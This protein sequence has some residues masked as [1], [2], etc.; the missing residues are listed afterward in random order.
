MSQ[1]L[2]LLDISFPSTND[3]STT[4]QYY[5]AKKDSTEGAVVLATDSLVAMGII[6]NK[7]KAGEAA[8]VRVAGTSK[9]IAGG[10]VH[11][12]D[13]VT[14]DANGKAIATTTNKNRVIGMALAEAVTGDIF[15]IML[16]H[17]TLSA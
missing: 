2:Y 7:P 13:W 12:G 17:F 1:G 8:L 11:Y 9:V 5:I 14:S 16:T 15:E 3:L 6:Q 4:G 10:T